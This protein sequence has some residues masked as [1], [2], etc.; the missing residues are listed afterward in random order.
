MTL[1]KD[2]EPDRW[3]K[4]VQHF[5]LMLK[6]VVNFRGIEAEAE[7]IDF[8]G[9]GRLKA[10][11]E[12]H[13]PSWGEVIELRRILNVPLS[14]FLINDPGDFPELEAA[15]SEALREAATMTPDERARLADEILSAP[16]RALIP[17]TPSEDDANSQLPE[18]ILR[19]VRN[20]SK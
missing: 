1:S 19:I 9:R 8:L 10:L 2:G 12:G 18:S 13:D 16:A 15:Y 11:Y 6:R 5:A 3:Q 7:I 20:T 17:R 14:T 4:P